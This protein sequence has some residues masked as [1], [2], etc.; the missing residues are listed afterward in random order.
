[1]LDLGHAHPVRTG[2]NPD[3]GAVASGR[4]P[5]SGVVPAPFPVPRAV[6]SEDGRDRRPSPGPG[7]LGHWADPL[8]RALLA[9][10]VRPM[11]SG[12]GSEF[13]DDIRRLLRM[14]LTSNRCSADEIARQ[15]LHIPRCRLPRSRRRSAI[16][17][18]VPSPGPS[19]TG[20]ARHRRRGGTKVLRSDPLRPK[21]S[22]DCPHWSSTRPQRA[23]SDPM[24]G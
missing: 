24:A 21:L 22:R 6:Q 12:P 13:R 5:I 10:R 8:P 3:R 2:L 19:G 16:Q 15:L 18:P 20:R 23:Y 17:T 4:L 11:K 1:V 9:E 7:S 14:R